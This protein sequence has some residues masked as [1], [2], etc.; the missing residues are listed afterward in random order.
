MSVE[1]R[2]YSVIFKVDRER[3][4]VV[5]SQICDLCV[6]RWCTF[7]CPAECFRLVED[8]VE[9]AHDGCLECGTCRQV[10]DKKAIDWRYPRG[11]YGVCFRYG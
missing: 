6:D 9:F 10:C 7:F 8:R 5:N 1:N 3:H 4:I 2:L 11:G